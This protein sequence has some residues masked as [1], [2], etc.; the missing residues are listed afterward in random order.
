MLAAMYFAVRHETRYRYDV[1]VSLGPHTLRLTP[2][3][4]RVQLHRHT[5]H[6]SPQPVAHNVFWDV[7]G[8]QVGELRFVGSCQELLIVSEFQLDTLPPLLPTFQPALPW[9]TDPH[10]PRAFYG[11]APAADSVRAFAAGIASEVGYDALAFLDRLAFVLFSTFER[12]VRTSGNANTAAD[13]LASRSGACRDLTVLFLEACRSLG[14]AGR[15]VSGYQA[16]AQTPDNQS[17]LHAWAEVRLQGVGFCGWDPMHGVRVGAGHVK[18]CAAPEQLATM[19]V[20]GGFT[21]AGTTVRS[22][23]DHSLRIQTR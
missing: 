3:P 22:T 7:F 8:N 16:A 19:P 13:T 4:D 12:G 1:P 6:A 11:L 20:E 18:L 9:P 2:Q 14:I 21:F 5:I 17:F 10:E 23:L 15:F